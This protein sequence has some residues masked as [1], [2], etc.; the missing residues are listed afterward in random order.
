MIETLSL[1]KQKM[2]TTKR[3]LS[4]KPNTTFV[5]VAK[6]SGNA[7]PERVDPSSR[8]SLERPTVELPLSRPSP[9]EPS[10]VI[11]AKID[12]GFGNRLFIRGQ[13]P[14]LTWEKG[15]QLTCID[16]KT[17]RW[18]GNGGQPVVC[19]FLLNDERWAQGPNVEALPGSKLEVVPVF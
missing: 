14:D 17:W 18:Q 5:R 11:D 6:R 12:V 4:V 8:Q 7:L 16:E 3:V 1:L 2:K 19:K 13:G 9:D 15:E 10:T